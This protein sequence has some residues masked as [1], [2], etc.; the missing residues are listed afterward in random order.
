MTEERPE[1]SPYYPPADDA[2]PAPTVLTVVMASGGGAGVLDEWLRIYFSRRREALIIELR[3][4]DRTLG[5]PQTI[6]ERPR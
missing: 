2:P 5:L 3:A 6:P 4:L 1:Y